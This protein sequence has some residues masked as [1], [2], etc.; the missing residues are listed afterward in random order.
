MR[1]SVLPALELE[2]TGDYFVAADSRDHRKE[3]EQKG[4]EAPGKSRLHLL[5]LRFAPSVDNEVNGGHEIDRHDDG[6]QQPADDGA[7]QGRVLLAAGFGTDGHGNHSED[8]G[9]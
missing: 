6:N 5:D 1:Y 4:A 9:E 3:R 8:R 7:G 2:E